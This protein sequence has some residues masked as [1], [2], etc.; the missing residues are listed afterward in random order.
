MEFKEMIE[1]AKLAWAILRGSDGNTISHAQREFESVGYNDGDKMN[2]LMSSNVIDLLR[3]FSAQGHSGFSASHARQLF[4]NLAAFKPLGPLTGADT[5]W[6]DHGDGMGDGTRWQNK[7]AGNVFKG[8]DGVAYD[9]DAVVFEEPSGSRFTG[10]YSRRPVTFPYTPRSVIAKV[11][12]E[13]TD[14]QKE[15]LATQAWAAA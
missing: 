1:R 10:R 8:A 5:E 15:M 12:E 2:Q 9:I 7:R 13:A 6:Y 4:G 11:P 3:V 14:V